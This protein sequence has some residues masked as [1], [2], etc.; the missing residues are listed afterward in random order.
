MQTIGLARIHSN[1]IFS[2][3]CCFST[4]LSTSSTPGNLSMS[5]CYLEHREQHLTADQHNRVR[6]RGNMEKAGATQVLL[7]SKLLF[8]TPNALRNKR[9]SHVCLRLNARAA[10]ALLSEQRKP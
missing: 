1:V 6:V 3:R 8:S 5:S 4:Q 10:D 9:Q 7:H 2:V